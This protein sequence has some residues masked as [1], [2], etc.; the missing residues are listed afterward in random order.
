MGLSL[1][2]DFGAAVLINPFLGTV[3]R[4]LAPSTTVSS[5]LRNPIYTVRS[6]RVGPCSSPPVPRETGPQG[7]YPRYVKSPHTSLHPSHPSP[8]GHKTTGT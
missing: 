3:P 7:L 2:G 4:S 6:H 8:P 1:A 5:I